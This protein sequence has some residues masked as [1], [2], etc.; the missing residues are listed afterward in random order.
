PEGALPVRSTSYNG[1][2]DWGD[3]DMPQ[4]DDNNGNSIHDPRARNGKIPLRPTRARVN[5]E[6]DDWQPNSETARLEGITRSMRKDS[7]QQRYGSVPGF[8]AKVGV[9]RDPNAPPR[10]R[11]ANPFAQQRGK[12][13]GGR[14]AGNVAGSG[15]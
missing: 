10:T 8:A 12:R 11:P 15:S 2:T 3:E 6:D 5:L 9:P 13:S 7:R 1:E 14:G 4:I